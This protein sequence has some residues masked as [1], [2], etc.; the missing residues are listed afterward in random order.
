MTAAYTEWTTAAAQIKWQLLTDWTTAVDTD[1][2]KAVDTDWTRAVDTDWELLTDWMTAA[3]RLNEHSCWHRLN[4]SCWHRL[5][6]H[7]C[8]DLTTATDTD[9]MTAAARTEGQLLKQTDSKLWHR[10]NNSCCTDYATA[11]EQ[12]KWQLLHRLNSCC[13]NWMTAAA[14]MDWQLLTHIEWQLLHRLNESLSAYETETNCALHNIKTTCSI[15]SLSRPRFRRLITQD[16]VSRVLFS[17]SK[18]VTLVFTSLL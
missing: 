16:A 6:E 12:T 15:A 8:W 2:M 4:N 11:A 17:Q 13:T 9:W 18:H 1:W 3:E 10:L 7:S 5:N 14:Q